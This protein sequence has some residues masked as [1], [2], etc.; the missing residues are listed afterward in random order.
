MFG[1]VAHLH[2][3]PGMESRLQ[4]LMKE[5]E[6]LNIPGHISSYVYRMDSGPNEYYLATIWQDRDSY[7]ANANSPEQ[8]ARYRKLLDCL[9]SEPEWHDGEIIYSQTGSRTR[10]Y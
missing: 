7:F 10:A 3:K 4:D 1:T 9:T 6:S 8:D 2:T 5:Y